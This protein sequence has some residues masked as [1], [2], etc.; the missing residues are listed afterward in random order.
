[1]A[2]PIDTALVSERYRVRL[3]DHFTQRVLLT[4]FIG[5]EQEN[6]LREPPN[7]GGVGRV[8]HFSRRTSPGWVPNPIPID[9]AA[10]ALGL[11]RIDDLHAQLFQN[12]GCNWRCWYC[13][14]PFE[15]LS[16]NPQHSDWIGAGQ[17]LDFLHVAQTEPSVIVLSGGEPEL[18]PEWILWLLK[19]L[20]RRGND[21]VYVWSDDNLST[22]YFWRF[23]SPADQEHIAT[24]R[25]YG[26]AA[27]FK[28]FDEESF[29][30]N[31]SAAPDFFQR[32]FGLMRR[33]IDTGMDVYG[34]VT[35]TTTRSTQLDVAIRHFVDRLQAVDENLPL[36]IVPL[37][38]KPFTPVRGR[39]NG[40]HEAALRNQWSALQAWSA[41]LMARFPDEMR[42]RSIVDV[43]FA[44][45]H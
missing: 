25:R 38:V 5:T 30:Y 28:G 33:L 15:L 10:H 36:R 32:Q 19:E 45:R 20:E 27:C 35:L 42:A 13:F 6:D 22:D 39:L 1:M 7:C 26:R 40:A 31:T 29:A 2:T 23:L 8:R 44:S 9:P 37:E 41:E 12:A 17:M 16:A 34:Y 14:V 24:H 21:R 18:T 3:L 4:N 11:G 43:P